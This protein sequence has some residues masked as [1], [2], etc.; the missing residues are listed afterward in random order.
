V[1]KSFAAIHCR[2]R[3]ASAL[4]VIAL[5]A[6]AA[7]CGS[8]V[9]ADEP[10]NGPDGIYRTILAR[11][12]EELSSRPLSDWYQ[13]LASDRTA[14]AMDFRRAIERSRRRGDAVGC[15]RLG[16]RSLLA[17]GVGDEFPRR[18]WEAA[19]DADWAERKFGKGVVDPEVCSSLLS[20]C[21]ELPAGEKYYLE[22]RLLRAKRLARSG[23]RAGEQAV[24]GQIVSTQNLSFDFLAPA[25]RTLGASLEASGDYRGT[26]DAYDLLE[27]AADR[28]SAAADCMLGA[29]LI[30]LRLGND[31]EAARLLRILQQAPAEVIR[32]ANGA[33][34][35]REL[36]ALMDTGQTARLSLGQRT[37]RMPAQYIA[38]PDAGNP[39]SRWIRSNGLAWYDYAGPEDPD[40]GRPQNPAL[41][42]LRPEGPAVPAEQI[43]LLLL[44]AQDPQAPLLQRQDAFREAARRILGAA[45]D[46]RKFNAIAASVIDN[47]DFDVETR[48]RT[49]ESVLAVLAAEGRKSDYDAWRRDPLGD[50]FNADFQEKL[51][52]LDREVALDRSSSQ[53]IL[54]LADG[55]RSTRMTPFAA[56]TMGDLFGCLLR[57]GDLS[58][59]EGLASTVPTW[60]LDAD[61]SRRAASI[62]SDFATRIQRASAL[63]PVH[64]ALAAALSARFPGPPVGLPQEYWDLRLDA[65]LPARSPEATFQACRFL[66]RTRRFN[67]DNLQFWATVLRALPRGRSQ[68]DVIADLLRSGLGAASDDGTRSQLIALFFTSVNVDDADVRLAIESEFAPYRGPADF[69]RSAFAIRLYEVQRDLRLGEPVPIETA[70]SDL[71]DPRSRTLQ[72]ELELRRDTLTGDRKALRRTVDRLGSTRLL[73]PGFIAQAI[74]AYKVLGRDLSGVLEAARRELRGA[75]LDSWLQHDE[76]SGNSALDLALAIGDPAALPSGWVKEMIS[77]PGDPIFQGRVRVV[78]AVLNRDWAKVESE[79]AGLNSSYPTS[80]SYYWYRGLALHKLGRDGEAAAALSTYVRHARDELEYPE[81]VEILKSLGGTAAS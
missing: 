44:A 77:G 70:F 75:L 21:D 7:P 15:L 72:L 26:L 40:A 14:N 66:V 80:Y 23:N 28:Y 61:A 68:P 1:N 58:S 3:L 38:G 17:L 20:L 5:F 36:T 55:L 33:A 34:Q 35:I 60:P 10:G 37:H 25:C 2:G 30:N 13:P 31:D 56:L 59:A 4:A 19:G 6:G 65:G 48:R 16:L 12:A 71:D 67:R 69:P 74:P 49:L 18:L 42:P 11:L 63:N 43:K 32:G 24:L 57:L 53:A 29:V 78:E 8:T 46:Y 9:K 64:E 41:E 27:G 52:I 47:R 39:V 81:A 22:G 62:Q 45:Q 54:G 51:A 76:S 79:S 73:S 50:G